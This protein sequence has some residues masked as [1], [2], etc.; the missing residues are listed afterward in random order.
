MR[1]GLLELL[2]RSRGQ[3]VSGEGMAGALGCTRAAIWKAV[4]ALRQEGY[5]I[6]AGPNRGYLLAGDSGCPAVE[7]IRPYLDN[8]D[9]YMEVCRELGSTNQE[10]RQRA[11]SEEAGHG[12]FVLAQSQSAGRGRRGRSF[13]SPDGAGLYLS[14]VLRPKGSLRESLILTA[15]AAVAVY[16][17]VRELTGIELDI[18]W[19]NDLYLN[20]RKVC[21]ILTEA[22][23]DFESGE[24][25]F[26]VVG[27]GI[28]LYREEQGFPPELENVA[29]ALYPDKASAEGL[30]RS[31]LAAE[32]VNRLLEET[33]ELK[34]PPE[35]RERSMLLGKEIR[36][37]GGSQTGTAQ[38]LDICSDG[39]LKVRM[40]DGTECILSCGEV[41]VTPQNIL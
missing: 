32:L 19:V 17:A 22:V 14:V 37:C 28:N 33:R 6:Q 30:N 26:A 23:T 2:E 9:V 21:G 24:I 25:E 39:R 16:K 8:P 27:I 20:G 38:A 35:Y 3:T 1:S 11:I 29:G 5:D 34:L 4:K 36:I 41:S 12:S 13:Y 40:E 31:R 18:K 15:E 10:A 7:S